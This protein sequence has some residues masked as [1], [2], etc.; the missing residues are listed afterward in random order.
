MTDATIALAFAERLLRR[1]PF[2]W[3][4]RLLTDHL[5]AGSIPHAVDV[6]TGLGKT[7][8]IALWL[9]A[10]AA[11]AKV[12]RRLVYVVDRRAV[13]DQ[14]TEEAEQLAAVL[15]DGSV[16]D[17]VVAALR[18]R[19]GLIGKQR[20]AVSTLRGQY[21]DNRRWMEDPSLPS[22][23]VGTVDMIGSRLLFSGYGVSPRMRPVHA[24]LLAADA[25]LVLDEA[26]L[27]P[28]FEGL[29]RRI[30][31]LR[32][33]DLPEVPP[34]RVMA[35]SA[36]QRDAEGFVFRLEP[37]DE[38]DTRVAKRLA[39]AKR[40]LVHDAVGEKELA[41]AMA[42][43]AWRNAQPSH[44]VVVFCNKRTVAQAVHTLLAKR[45][46]AHDRAIP[47]ELLV[48]ERR[49]HERQSLA[50]SAAFQRF[51]PSRHSNGS[52][53]TSPAFL[54]ATSAGEVGVDLDADHM[55][56][57]LVEWERMVQRLGRV[58]RRPE[59]AVDSR[60]EIIPVLDD[61]KEDSNA[62]P[63]EKRGAPAVAR[64]A[65]EL[66]EHQHWVVEEFRR[67]AGRLEIGETRR[68]GLEVAA[69]H[70]DTGKGRPLWQR[71]MG[72]PADGKVY[73]KTIGRT[74]PRLLMI[75]GRTF[76]HEFGSLGELSQISY[77]ST[78]IAANRTGPTMASAYSVTSPMGSRS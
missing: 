28:P 39:A 45:I 62:E 53:P 14:A 61:R 40:V 65:Q 26:H 66:D 57:D 47:I 41:H 25:L 24:G 23:I 19:L 36:T 59:P 73:A 27:V 49:V 18:E 9:A 55:V 42:A 5:L 60:I 11:G 3:Q 7:A 75:G 54:V 4:A 46:K 76:R 64:R 31:Q 30:Q 58:N 63:P 8:V 2:S 43:T 16:T 10:F 52:L 35:L 72:A 1:T 70:H 68:H 71:A 33:E 32:S 51:V 38:N 12:P 67:I 37:D 56:C 50:H 69:A 77:A 74:N 15:G 78:T 21:A 29:M 6:P 22:I 44:A 17:H 20:L 13:V 34:F 48:G